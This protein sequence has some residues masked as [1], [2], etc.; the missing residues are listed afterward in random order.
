VA[1]SLLAF[2]E[3]LQHNLSILSLTRLECLSITSKWKN[4]LKTFKGWY[5]R[6]GSPRLTQTSK[7]FF[8][9]IVWNRIK[10]YKRKSPRCQFRLKTTIHRRRR[11]PLKPE[12]TPYHLC[13][14][15]PSGDI[16]A[17]ALHEPFPGRRNCTGRA[18]TGCSYASWPRCRSYSKEVP[19]SSHRCSNA[20]S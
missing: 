11:I 15:H 5:A 1:R 6:R 20:F 10:D 4:K 9:G 12:A 8:S 7:A 2:G 16:H 19:A 13:R 17:T 14:R 18:E 3:Y